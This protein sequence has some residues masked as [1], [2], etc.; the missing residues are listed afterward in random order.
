MTFI[1]IRGSSSTSAVATADMSVGLY[2]NIFTVEKQGLG[3]LSVTSLFYV[4]NYLCNVSEV[5]WHNLCLQ[6]WPREK[7]KWALILRRNKFY[8]EKGRKMGRS[9]RVRRLI[10]KEVTGEGVDFRTVQ[11]R[12]STYL[13]FKNT[14]V[15]QIE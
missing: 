3:Y 9:W 4:S 1:I 13:Y 6:A 7:V 10:S 11:F 5:Q 12:Q 8:P 2:D 15:L 14:V